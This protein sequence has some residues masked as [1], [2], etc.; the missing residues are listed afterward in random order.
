M[1]ITVI[2]QAR[3]GSTRLPGKINLPLGT[4]TVLEHVIHRVSTANIPDAIMVATTTS[5]LDDKTVELAKKSNALIFRGSE[6]DVLNRFY[7]A[8]KSISASIIVRIT[9]DCPFIDPI[10]LDNML[11]HFM[12]TKGSDYLSNTIERTYPRG[13]DI[14]IFS[15]HALSVA[16]KNAAHTFEREH[17]TP[18][19]YHHPE[20]FKISQYTQTKNHAHYRLTLD[21]PE[22]WQLI[23]TLYQRLDEQKKSKDTASIL[24]LLE[25]EPALLKINQH[26]Q[27]INDIRK[28]KGRLNESNV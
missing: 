14:E 11:E 26:I 3:M 2:I 17:V 25:H 21:T 16:E 10:L 18:Y 9:A 13:L 24:N 27:Q 28:L 1:T 23:S 20:V 5:D 8:A 4:T 6:E 12:S 19:I 15:F 22:D 7:E